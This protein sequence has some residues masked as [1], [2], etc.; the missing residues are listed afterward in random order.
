M[1]IN[2]KLFYL[3]LV[4][5]IINQ[6]CYIGW[7][8]NPQRRWAQHCSAAQN[9]SDIYFHKALRKYGKENFL[10]DI[11]QCFDTEEEVKQAEI[12]WINS[13]KEYVIL[14]NSTLG[15]EGTVGWIP[16]EEFKQ[17]LSEIRSGK[18]NPFFGKTHA[19]ETLEKMRAASTGKNNPNFGKSLYGKYNH[20]YGKR[21]TNASK[22]AIS[23]SKI[24]L[25]GGENNPR[26]LLL[27]TDIPIIRDKWSTANY[28]LMELAK[29]YKVTKS[30]IHCIVT[31]KSW[32]VSD[33]EYL[34]L[35]EKRKNNLFKIK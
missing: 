20:F 7:S 25:Q 19:P 9:N 21:H 31:N 5:N 13:L 24:G 4:T 14:Y 1:K 29:E 18:Q 33:E 27:A 22:Q 32:K 30:C 26:A 10:C 12:Y 35:K 11:I 15:G 2:G 16:S 17:H 3:Y 6:K 23:V 34:I 8:H 28:T